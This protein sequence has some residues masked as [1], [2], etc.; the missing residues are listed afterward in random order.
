MATPNPEITHLM[1][2]DFDMN[3]L[4]HFHIMTGPFNS[5]VLHYNSTRMSQNGEIYYTENLN[6]DKLDEISN[7]L[8]DRELARLL[9]EFILIINP[10]YLNQLKYIQLRYKSLGLIT[11]ERLYVEQH[12]YG[13]EVDIQRCESTLLSE[14]YPSPYIPMY[15]IEL[16]LLMVVG[17]SIYKIIRRVCY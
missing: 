7:R 14:Y 9:R 11:I 6:P 16:G 13:V 10:D 1:G 8:E 17:F 5:P 15:S 3:T 2:L 4:K 12:S